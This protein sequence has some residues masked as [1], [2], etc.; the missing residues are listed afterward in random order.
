[1]RFGIRNRAEVACVFRMQEATMVN[2]IRMV[3]AVW[4]AAA[5][6][7]SALAAEQGRSAA[8]DQNA[9]GQF[10]SQARQG[11]QNLSQRLDRSGGVIQPPANVDP[12]MHVA[13]PA[14]GDKMPVLPAPGSPGADPSIKPK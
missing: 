7:A 14:T 13:P 3:V 4:I 2:C 5:F 10:D 12:Q 11:D 1:L 8:P 6:S 9:P